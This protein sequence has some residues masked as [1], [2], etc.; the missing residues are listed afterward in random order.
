MYVCLFGV[1]GKWRNLVD[2][3]EIQSVGV[4]FEFKMQ[5]EVFI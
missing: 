3:V 5:K 2:I 4:L 1:F